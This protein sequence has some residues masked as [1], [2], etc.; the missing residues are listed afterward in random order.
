MLFTK[1]GLFLVARVW[2]T[3]DQNIGCSGLPWISTMHDSKVPLP[4][5]NP[6]VMLAMGW[7]GRTVNWYYKAGGNWSRYSS[8]EPSKIENPYFNL[9]LIWVGNPFTNTGS[10]EAYFYQAGVSSNKATSFGQVTFHCPAYYDRQG[11]K[12]CI[13]AAAIDGGSSHWKVLWKWGLPNNNARVAVD[14]TGVTVTLG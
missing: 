7:D 6:S 4:A 1:E 8:F 5:S 11:E 14:G 12:Q 13:P 10:S 3:C 9:G 2:E